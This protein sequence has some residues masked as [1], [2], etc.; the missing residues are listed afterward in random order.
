MAKPFFKLAAP[1]S[2]KMCLDG[3]H[4]KPKTSLGR[5]FEI[6]KN[7]R[8]QFFKYF[9]ESKNHEFQF[10]EKKLKTKQ[11]SIQAMSKTLK[12]AIVFRKESLG[13]LAGS[14]TFS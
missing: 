2:S 10:F 3:A 9:T 8:I 11:P 1:C 13:S 12:E 6:L 14:L 5:F 4:Y 7:C